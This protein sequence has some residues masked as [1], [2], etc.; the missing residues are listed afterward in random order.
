MK[1]EFIITG[2]SKETKQFVFLVEDNA[3]GGYLFF[4]DHFDSARTFA[5]LE[6]ARKYSNCS[7]SMIANKIEKG[8]LKIQEVIYNLREIENKNMQ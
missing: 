7:Y 3:S 6:S 2:I 5:S 8:S 1:S 4:S